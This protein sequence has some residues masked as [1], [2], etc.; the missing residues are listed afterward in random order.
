MSVVG[1]GTP[2]VGHARER[3]TCWLTSPARH[4]WT[5]TAVQRSYF[6]DFLLVVV[7][8]VH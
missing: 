7:V 2:G 8:R 5:W 6:E 4:T 1:W 3:A